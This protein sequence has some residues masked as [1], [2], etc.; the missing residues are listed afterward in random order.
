MLS[1]ELSEAE[2]FWM[3]CHIIEVKLPVDFYAK[4]IGLCLDQKVLEHL[5]DVHLPRLSKHFNQKDNLIVIPALSF[6]WV[7]LFV[8]FL[9]L[10][11]EYF[12]WDLF[13][14]KGSSVLFM[15][16]LTILSVLSESILS[17]SGPML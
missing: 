7:N 14:L 4:M 16:T 5:I 6:S 2:C 3:L 12:V 1:A 10:E 8:N 9:S 17:E 13:C 15:V 11:T